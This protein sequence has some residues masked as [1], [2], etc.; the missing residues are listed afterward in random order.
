MYIEGGYANFDASSLY[1]LNG[2]GYTRFY[3]YQDSR[4]IQMVRLSLILTLFSMAKEKNEEY[5]KNK[6]YAH[7]YVTTI[8]MS[9]DGGREYEQRNVCDT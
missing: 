9:C 1:Y 3:N 2:N 7:H 4:K 8:T 6:D 5:E